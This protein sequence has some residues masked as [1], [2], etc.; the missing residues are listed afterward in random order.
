MNRLLPIS[1]LAGVITAAVVLMFAVVV[2][3]CVL[4]ADLTETVRRIK[5][6]IVGV[7]TYQEVRRPPSQLLGTGF[8]VS[9]GTLVLT[10]NHVV[11]TKADQD[12]YRLLVVFT[13]SGRDSRVVPVTVVATD[14]L[15]DVA[16]LRLSEGR[17][18]ALELGDD[19][20]VAEGQSIAFTGFPIGAVLGLYPVTHRGIVAARTPIAVPQVSQ[21]NLDARMIRML[22][23]RFE[24]FQLDATAYPG[25][26]GSP[27]YD[28]AT[29][30]VVGIVSSVFVKDAKERALTDP[31]GITFAVPIRFARELLRQTA[32]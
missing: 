18:P 9:D 20:D 17:L 24:V 2:P 12:Q 31:S 22:R 4:A 13:G 10:S 29:G 28:Q 6:G 27:L 5:P 19:A 14:V 21:G 15:H 16:V 11:N 1:R 32:P 7:G 23:E 25:N 30:R 3:R 26:S 8:A